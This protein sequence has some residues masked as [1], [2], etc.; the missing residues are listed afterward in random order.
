MRLSALH[1]VRWDFEEVREQSRFR[2]EKDNDL[3]A[4]P[5]DLPGYADDRGSDN[6]TGLLDTNSTTHTL[7]FDRMTS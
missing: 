6:R 2:R 3:A 4:R 1:N 5:T 7:S